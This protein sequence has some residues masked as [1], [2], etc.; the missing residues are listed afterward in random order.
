MN[1]EL[2]EGDVIRHKASGAEWL[3]RGNGVYECISA[4]LEGWNTKV[5]EIARTSPVSN[6][7]DAGWFTG[8]ELSDSFEY[9]V[10]KVRYEAAGSR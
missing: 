10:K 4:G 1:Y 6:R 2:Q 7:I 8:W 3:Y 5:G 9:W